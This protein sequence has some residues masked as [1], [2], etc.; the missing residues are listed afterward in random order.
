ME[1][2]LFEWCA[3]DLMCDTILKFYGCT[4][5]VSIGSFKAGDLVPRIYV[6]FEHGVLKICDKDEK[7][8][9][10]H[11][12]RMVLDDGDSE[13][14]CEHACSCRHRESIAAHYSA[15]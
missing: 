15:E 7:L 12:V 2:A 6:D 14:S 10:E 1:T 4:L 3:W 13:A 8:L 11:K 9:S 5:K